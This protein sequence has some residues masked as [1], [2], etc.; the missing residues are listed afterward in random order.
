MKLAGCELIIG[1]NCEPIFLIRDI[2]IIVHFLL[3][4]K[5]IVIFELKYMVII[6]HLI[7]INLERET[8]RDG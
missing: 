1:R 2:G 8:K 4:G 6:H 7:P 3:F 5:Y